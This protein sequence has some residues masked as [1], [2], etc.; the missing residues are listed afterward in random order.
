MQLQYGWNKSGK[1]VRMSRM[2]KKDPEIIHSCVMERV[3]RM[4]NEETAQGKSTPAISGRVQGNNLKN[5][6]CFS[7]K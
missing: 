7:A 1:R 4:E 2:Q 5:L 6:I 3:G